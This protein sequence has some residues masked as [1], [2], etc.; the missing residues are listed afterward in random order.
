MHA[1]SLRQ[2]G[3][4]SL[5]CVRLLSLSPCYVHIR[6]CCRACGASALPMQQHVQKCA[7]QQLRARSLMWWS[8]GPTCWWHGNMRLPATATPHHPSPQLQATTRPH[9][10]IRSPSNS[11]RISSMGH[12]MDPQQIRAQQRPDPPQSHQNRPR[13]SQ[14]SQDVRG[15]FGLTQTLPPM[16][17]S[18]TRFPLP[19]RTT[20]N[21]ARQVARPRSGYLQIGRQCLI[22]WSERPQNW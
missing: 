11:A 2:P 5:R 9:H 13:S 8:G 12:T 4:P 22:G 17:L 10:L 19:C 7:Q 18:I 15:H 21:I 14:A 6:A 20:P 3:G 1:S 16:G